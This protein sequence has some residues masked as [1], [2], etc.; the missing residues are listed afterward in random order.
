MFETGPNLKIRRQAKLG[1]LAAVLGFSANMAGH[2][3]QPKD[4]AAR[5]ADSFVD[6]IGLVGLGGPYVYP[7]DDGRKNLY[8]KFPIAP[9]YRMGV[10]HARYEIRPGM[11]LEPLIE[12]AREGVRI[13][14]LVSWLWTDPFVNFDANI[15]D[16]LDTLHKLPRG[17]VDAI[18]GNNESDMPITSGDFPRYPASTAAAQANQAVLYRAVKA[19]PAFKAVPVIAWTLG[20]NWPWGGYVGYG[21]FVS[22]DFDY[23]SLHS[24]PG[25]DTIDGSMF[26]PGHTEFMKLTNSII[27]PGGKA[28]PIVVTET[29]AIYSMTGPD[30]VE[31]NSEWAQA[32]KITMILADDF[33]LGIVRTYLYSVGGEKPFSL[34]TRDDGTPRP[35]G[36]ALSFLTSTLGEAKW[37]AARLVWTAP[38][39]A[40]GC[41]ALSLSAIPPTIHYL[42]LQKSDRSFYL[43]I[44]N[45]VML[46]DEKN[47]RDFQNPPVKVVVDI[48][49]LVPLARAETM[50]MMKDGSY[51]TLPASL[52]G[53]SPQQSLTLAV[54]D[55]VM[56][57]HL[58]PGT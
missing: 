48:A 26:A 6:S 33:R 38:S 22:T 18:E 31:H 24:Y 2:A 46:W 20:K 39:F 35:A 8:K 58:I 9:K 55:S 56:L 47:G 29:G 28:K 19:D 50:T 1:V 14:A 30:K 15:A 10:R 12:A 40:P 45:D 27:P 25:N 32:K 21:K 11:D 57:V 52:E 51:S 54:P 4:V 17:S 13:D 36:C 3:D 53:S 5:S 43:L 34:D 41:L 7:Y 23:Q 42:L 37:D 49:S 16:V 44:W